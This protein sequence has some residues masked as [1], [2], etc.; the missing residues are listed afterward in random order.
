MRDV[1][2]TNTPQ[3]LQ[4]AC[5]VDPRDSRAFDSVN[6]GKICAIYGKQRKI[7]NL[8]E[9]ENSRLKAFVWAVDFERAGDAREASVF[10][11]LAK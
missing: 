8:G 1:K 4:F 3:S 10:G 2:G 6:L 9:T 7:D 5:S 11:S